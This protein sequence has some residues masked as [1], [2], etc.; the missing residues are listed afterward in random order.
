MFHFSWK[1][2]TYMGAKDALTSVPLGFRRFFVFK[3]SVSLQVVLDDHTFQY[4]VKLEHWQV[5][6]KKKRFGRGPQVVGCLLGLCLG[7][8]LFTW[9]HSFGS[10]S[11]PRTSGHCATVFGFSILHP[12]IHMKFQPM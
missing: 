7:P 12:W 11:V 3:M 8:A 10:A 4:P 6:T 9:L 1:Y 2:A 5:M